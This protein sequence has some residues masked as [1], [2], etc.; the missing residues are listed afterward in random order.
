MSGHDHTFEY[1]N[2]GDGIDYIDTGGT[3]TCDSSTAHSNTIPKDSLKFH[4]CDQGGFTRIRV[5]YSGLTTY[6][7]YGSDSKVKYTV[8]TRKPRDV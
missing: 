3:H 4:G 7:Y 6:Y 8:P 1:I 5:D 2:T